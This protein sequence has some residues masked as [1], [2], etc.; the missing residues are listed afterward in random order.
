MVVVCVVWVVWPSS[1]PLPSVVDEVAQIA[2][3]GY[4]EVLLL[5]QN[6]NSYHDKDTVYSVTPLGDAGDADSQNPAQGFVT[7]GYTTS[8][9]FTNLFRCDTLY[10]VW[11]SNCIEG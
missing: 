6:V 11:L 2:A 10:T 1:R 8:R 3:A 9:G 4:K 7:R 5:G